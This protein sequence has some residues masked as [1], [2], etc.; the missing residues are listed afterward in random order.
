M[1]TFIVILDARLQHFARKDGRECG[2]LNGRKK[3]GGWAAP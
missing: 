2:D 3:R 1:K